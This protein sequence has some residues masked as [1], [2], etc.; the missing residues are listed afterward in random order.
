MDR[1]GRKAPLRWYL[2]E[3]RL[4][5]GVTAERLAERLDTNKGQISKLENGRQ[6]MNDEWIIGYADAL[7]VEPRD[8]L[9]DPKSPDLTGLLAKAT[10]D[11]IAKIREIAEIIIGKSAA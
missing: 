9:R 2:R 10:P 11:Q 8:L 4:H 7:G 5:K 1:I 6:R 3:W